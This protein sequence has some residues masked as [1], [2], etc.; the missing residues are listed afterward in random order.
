M[1]LEWVLREGSWSLKEIRPRVVEIW[2]DIY[3]GAI[4]ALT[5]NM[6]RRYQAVIRSRGENTHY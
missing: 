4:R 2:E 6:H 3:Q 1:Y 5:E